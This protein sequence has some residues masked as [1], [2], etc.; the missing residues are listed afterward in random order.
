MCYNYTNKDKAGE[1]MQAFEPDRNQVEIIE[2]MTIEYPYW[3]RIHRHVIRRRHSTANLI[4]KNLYHLKELPNE[5]DSEFQTRNILSETWGLLIK[6]LQENPGSQNI[7]GTEQT[8][9]LRNTNK[10]VYPA[11]P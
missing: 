3:R 11:F 6:E 1:R 2:D 5:T 9:R 4:P 10:I 8:N 7:T